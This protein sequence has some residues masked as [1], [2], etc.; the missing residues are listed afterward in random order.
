MGVSPPALS[1]HPL[2]D[3]IHTTDAEFLCLIRVISYALLLFASSPLLL[4]HTY[5]PNLLQHI[6]LLVQ[7][8][9]LQVPSLLSSDCAF[10]YHVTNNVVV[11]IY[12]YISTV[13][14]YIHH[15]S[16]FVIVKYILLNE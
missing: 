9:P 3:E 7:Q 13:R 1:S 14:S 16:L 2:T 10:P 8:V 15:Y 11:P 4:Y 6:Q 5:C 12:D